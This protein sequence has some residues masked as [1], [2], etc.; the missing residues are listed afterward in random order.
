MNEK[1]VSLPVDADGYAHIAQKKIRQQLYRDAIPYLEKAISLNSKQDYYIA[2]AT[3]LVK[4]GRTEEGVHTL[5]ERIVK[6]E[7]FAVYFYQLSQIYT[8]IR[9]P[10]K[11]FLYGLYYVQLTDDQD[12]FD[13]LK[14]TFEVTYTSQTAVEAESTLYVAQ[15]LFQYLF[16]HGC[17]DE[18]IDWLSSQPVHIQERKEMRNLKAMAYLF[19]SKYQ[20]AE[21]LL[22]QLLAEDETDI[23]ALCHYT[24]LLYNTH[25]HEKFNHYLQRLNKLHPINEDESFKL[26]IV[27]SFLKQ[28]ETSQQLLL[29]LYKKKNLKNAQL[30]HALS[31][32]YFALGQEKE[33]EET[34]RKLQS[35]S[36]A[37]LSPK[38]VHDTSRF[39]EKDILPLLHSDDRHARI[40]GLFKLSQ[41]PYKEAIISKELWDQLEQL[42]DYEKLYLSYIFNELHLVKLDYIHQGLVLLW[43]H[44]QSTELLISWVDKAQALIELNELKEVTAYAAACYY[45]Y[46]K[47]T[48]AISIQHCAERFELTR[49][50][51]TKALDFYKQNSI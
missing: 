12:Y 50:R 40:V 38:E 32:N 5:F 3:C 4:A 23:H 7:E 41:L 28:Y 24:L 19:M 13:T 34:W 31:F 35:F 45:L 37:A 6:E 51:L 17:I 14:K 2:L 43:Q 48:A 26:G 9:E 29:P 33:S 39:I 49:Y 30:L 27:L 46:M 11:A 36:T 44:D 18:S 22:D 8:E 16:S 10:N 47:R 25:Q 21:A 42:G 20:E 1:I 15:Q